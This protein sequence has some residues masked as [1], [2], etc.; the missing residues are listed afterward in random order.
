MKDETAVVIDTAST[1]KFHELSSEIAAILLN[2]E[3]FD[4][5]LP[6]LLSEE[7]VSSFSLIE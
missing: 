1:Y 2:E 3:S 4:M 5:D 7:E 6:F